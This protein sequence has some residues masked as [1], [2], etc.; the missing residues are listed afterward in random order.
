HE[1]QIAGFVV[2]KCANS[3]LL[4]DPITRVVIRGPERTIQV[5]GAIA[6]GDESIHNGRL[7]RAG[8]ARQ[9]DSL[10]WAESELTIACE[11]AMSSASLACAWIERTTP[12]VE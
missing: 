8:H 5:D 1:Q 11:R 6:Q 2:E 10:H 12:E 9:Q 7:A 3:I 4:P